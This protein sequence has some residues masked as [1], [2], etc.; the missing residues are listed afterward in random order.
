MLK[1]KVDVFLGVSTMTAELLYGSGCRSNS[2]DVAGAEQRIGR[3][4]SLGIECGEGT[5]ETAPVSATP[6][7]VKRG[8][9][10]TG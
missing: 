4:R 7:K 9:K 2:A 10:Y 6:R 3:H 1:Y 8:K 5:P